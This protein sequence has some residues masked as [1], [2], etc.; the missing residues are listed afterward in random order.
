MATEC[1][2]VTETVVPD[3]AAVRLR[4]ATECEA[5]AQCEAVAEA[6]D[7]ASAAE[8]NAEAIPAF[9]VS[10]TDADNEEQSLVGDG[11]GNDEEAKNNLNKK[12]WTDEE[13]RILGEVVVKEGAQKWSAVAAAL[14]G[15]AGK[16]CRERWY[17]HICPEVRKGSWTAEEERIIMESVREHGTK[18]SFIVK[19]LPGRTD[20]AIKNRYNSAMRRKTRLQRLE[21]ATANGEAIASRPRGRPGG[22]GKSKRKRED[23][24]AAACLSSLRADGEGAAVASAEGAGP[25]DEP[26]P[27]P[28]KA[29]RPSRSRAARVSKA[30]RTSAKPLPQFF[31]PT[32]N[33]TGFS[34]TGLGVSPSV[35][36]R[37][38]QLAAM[39]TSGEVYIWIYSCIIYIH[40]CRSIYRAS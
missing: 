36:E 11:D 16:Q 12:T 33:F 35:D 10:D 1:E 3:S 40:L 29:P 15:R 26:A 24:E 4:M 18:W 34:P 7:P 28:A 37:M 27:K 25:S 20:N 17:N 32:D 31:S 14:P 38:G 22:S 5:V 30:Q 9:L 2:A 8:A 6:L 39:L 21:E 13:D 23:V 19:Q